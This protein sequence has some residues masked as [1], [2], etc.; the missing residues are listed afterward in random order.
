VSSWRNSRAEVHNHLLEAAEPLAATLL[1]AVEA[2][3]QAGNPG[4]TAFCKAVGLLH[5]DVNAVQLAV[6][7]GVAD[8]NRLQLEVLKSCKRKDG[9]ESGLLG[10]GSKHLVEIDARMPSKALG[11]EASLIALDGAFRVALDLEDPLG[12]NGLAP[13]WQLDKLPRAVLKMSLHLAH[14]G[15]VP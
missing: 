3:E 14:H 1:E 11:D 2:L 4:Q 5:I 8:V 15:L 12:A 10:C 9:A 6:E 7:V 13:W